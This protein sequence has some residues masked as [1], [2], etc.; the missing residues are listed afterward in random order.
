MPWIKNNKGRVVEVTQQQKDFM[1]GKQLDKKGRPV[2]RQITEMGATEP[3]AAE[4]KAARERMTKPS[5]KVS[6]A[7]VGTKTA[8]SANKAENKN[9]DENKAPEK[10]ATPDDSWT[11]PELKKFAEENDIDVNGITKKSEIIE[12][13]NESTADSGN[14][15][16]GGSESAPQ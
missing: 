10:S 6:G 15:D 13:I 8:E 2:P 7:K 16:E 12:A 5:D 9:E 1:L 14:D 4:I 3:T 11:I